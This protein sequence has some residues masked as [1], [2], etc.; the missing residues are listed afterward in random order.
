MG[1]VETDQ[2]ITDDVRDEPQEDNNEIQVV[3]EENP[4][5]AS[6]SG[7]TNQGLEQNG[8]DDDDSSIDEHDIDLMD[9]ADREKDVFRNKTVLY[10]S[11]LARK[12]PKVL[13][14]KSSM[15]H[16]N[17]LTIAIFYGLPVIQL[18]LT[19][20]NITNKTGNQDMCYFNFLCTH[21][22]G[23]VTDFNHVFSNL[24][25]VS[26]GILFILIGKSKLRFFS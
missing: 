5:Q 9:D 19:F 15:Y 25:Y 10:V 23:M 1:I 12:S 20:Q 22:L 26:L 16:W 11:D 8:I 3:E 13:A 7:N 18:V 6:T 2:I 21:P 14:K 17:L 4:V 24:G